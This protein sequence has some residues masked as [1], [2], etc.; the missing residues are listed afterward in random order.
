[1]ISAPVALEQNAVQ[2]PSNPNEIQ[3]SS[4]VQ[5]E[6]DTKNADMVQP[7]VQPPKTGKLTC[8]SQEISFFEK[9][10][11][12]STFLRHQPNFHV[13]CYNLVLLT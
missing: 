4:Q 2:V 12:I 5:P 10:K 3:Q 6:A 1:M 11:K 8:A 7:R 9:K 13:N